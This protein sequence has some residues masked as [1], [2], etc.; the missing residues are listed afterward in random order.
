MVKRKGYT[1]LRYG[2]VRHLARNVRATYTNTKSTMP[3]GGS[4]TPAGP[5]GG[6]NQQ[7]YT[8]SSLAP[9][10]NVQSSYEFSVSISD[11][12]I[13]KENKN[14]SVVYYVLQLD[15]LPP[16][17][18]GGKVAW[19][20]S[21]R[22]SDFVK[23][24]SEL[25]LCG[26]ASLPALPPKTWLTDRLDEKLIATRKI[27]LA[28]FMNAIIL[29]KPLFKT[30][31]V[32]YFLKTSEFYK[33]KSL[34][35]SRAAGSDGAS[36]AQ[37]SQDSSGSVSV[38]SSR[39]RSRLGQH[40]SLIPSP[41]APTPSTTPQASGGR[42][43]SFGTTRN[44]AVR[45][46]SVSIDGSENNALE[47][48]WGSVLPLGGAESINPDQQMLLTLSTTTILVDMPMNLDSNRALFAG[49][50]WLDAYQAGGPDGTGRAGQVSVSFRKTTGPGQA[51]GDA[52]TIESTSFG[53]LVYLGILLPLLV[54]VYILITDYSVEKVSVGMAVFV[55]SASVLI[56][57]EGATTPPVPGSEN[58]EGSKNVNS[59][60]AVI[61]NAYEEQMGSSAEILV[62]PQADPVYMNHSGT[63]AID[64]KLSKTTTE[65][66]MIAIGLNWAMRKIALAM[67]TE[68]KTQ[69]T[70]Y[71]IK[72]TLHLGNGGKKITPD[73]EDRTYPLDGKTYHLKDKEGSDVFLTH[74]FVPEKGLIISDTNNTTKQIRIVDH[75][76]LKNGGKWISQVIK[77]YAQGKEPTVCDLIKV[78]K[79]PP[80]EGSFLD[81]KDGGLPDPEGFVAPEGCTVVKSEDEVA[82]D[83]VQREEEPYSGAGSK[84]SVSKREVESQSSP[85]EEKL[86]DWQALFALATLRVRKEKSLSNAQK[87]DFY[88]LFKQASVGDNKGTSRP[89]G[90]VDPVGAAKWDGWKKYKGMS[91]NDAKK[92]YIDLLTE[93][94]PNW[95]KH[96][97]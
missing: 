32:R 65:P 8:P 47:A 97:K 28:S 26:F 7:L 22:Y 53:S 1:F 69:H 83:S 51:N 12:V 59:Q 13:D 88:G 43:S 42:S 37:G 21:R 25:A 71:G 23:L 56:K 49:E 93:V 57:S 33:L 15:A 73:N 40:V 46:M 39:A 77:T 80:V 91:P 54:A 90:F 50:V 29:D 86:A 45:L 16:R 70:L 6:Q 87:V 30:R 63:W 58:P 9:T 60:Y 35:G 64:R 44:S 78:R 2:T 18:Q 3:S 67:A 76:V 66:M 27:S 4:D 79:T 84:R 34:A 10:P 19:T 11:V 48:R 38:V 72:R 96:E 85:R 75:Q 82:K 81:G 61:F 24:K 95:Q 31:L 14:K 92:K 17:G 62:V 52:D 68:T 36:L 94:S 89:S 74:S 5:F 41:S 55:V 20:V